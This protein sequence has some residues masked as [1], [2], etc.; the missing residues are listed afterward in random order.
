MCYACVH[1]HV[2]VHVFT[3]VSSLL[4]SPLLPNTH[5]ECGPRGTLANLSAELKTHAHIG[6]LHVKQYLW[7]PW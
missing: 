4:C 3:C 2:Y 6:L 5:N 1:V 7:S